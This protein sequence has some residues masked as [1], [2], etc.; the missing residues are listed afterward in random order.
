[1]RINLLFTSMNYSLIQ[2]ELV[3]SR[4]SIYT[5][6]NQVERL[7]NETDENSNLYSKISEGFDSEIKSEVIV[8][9]DLN[10]YNAKNSYC[11]YYDLEM[12]QKKNE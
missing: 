12:K 6:V 4:K 11:Y 7:I 3:V 10:S 8:I 5:W 9:C 1:M 2:K